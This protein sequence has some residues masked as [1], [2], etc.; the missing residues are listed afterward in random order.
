MIFKYRGTTIRLFST[1]LFIL[2][3]LG[4]CAIFA[5]F[6]LHEMIT[7]NPLNHSDSPPDESGGLDLNVAQTGSRLQE[8]VKTAIVGSN[9]AA[10]ENINKN[11][12]QER[13][14]T[15]LHA[16]V[17]ISQNRSVMPEIAKLRD[18]VRSLNEKEYIR[19]V[20]KFGTEFSQSSIVIIIQVHDR[21]DYF[22]HL[23]KS[24]SRAKGIENAFLVISNDYYSEEI[25]RH[26]ESIDFCR[27]LQIFFPFSYQ[28]YPNQFPGTDPNDC[29]RDITKEKAREIGCNNA[30]TPDMFGHYRESKYTMTKHHWWWK[31]NKVFDMLNVTK[32][33]MGPVLFLEEDYY[34][35]PDFYH[36]LRLL[37]DKKM[38]GC[39]DSCDFITLGTYRNV[40][41]YAVNG[42]EN[43]A[44]LSDWHSHEHNMG[45]AFDRT[46]WNK[47]KKCSEVFCKSY[48]EYNWDW[49]LMKISMSCLQHPF[50]SLILRGPRVFHLGECGLHHKKTNCNIEATV[51]KYQSI[52]D[53]NSNNF[54][55]STVDIQPG[56]TGQGS[57]ISP[58]GGWGDSRDHALCFQLMQSR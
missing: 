43:V 14:A 48:D 37:Y 13:I 20:D 42:A 53:R 26:V 8:D 12:P 40:D 39:S 19:N 41:N 44:E 51:N 28:L 3:T 58:N 46:T 25:N 54:Y 32:T 52:I 16:T 57:K 2:V 38:S 56:K 22:S 11:V 5:V 49:S 6:T 15:T 50:K 36:M 35:S 4:V 29:P 24:L 18:F 21:V 27:V 34:V 17:K 31:I 47:I 10:N 55:P 45:L 7:F 1:K 30:E 33:Y 9:A 23:L